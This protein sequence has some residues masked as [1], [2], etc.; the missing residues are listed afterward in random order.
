MSEQFRT[1]IQE[2]GHVVLPAAVRRLLGL[3]FGDEIV[4]R[5][6]N[7]ELILSPVADAVKRFQ[8]AVRN[9][10]P[11]DSSLSDDL[12]AERRAEAAREN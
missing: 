12:I 5:V 9:H 3:D 10:V 8:S 4:N 1:Q 6:A 2:H 11:A 7:R